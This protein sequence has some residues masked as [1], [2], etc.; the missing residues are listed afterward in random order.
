MTKVNLTN[1][2]KTNS[3][4]FSSDIFKPDV[5]FIGPKILK[6]SITFIIYIL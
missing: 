6:Y 1:G 5:F 2:N 4:I 3:D